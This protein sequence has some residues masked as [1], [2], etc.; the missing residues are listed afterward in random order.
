[1]QG[2]K[3]LKIV[4]RPRMN[5]D[6]GGLSC[7]DPV[8]SQILAC[9][10]ITKTEELDNSLKGL[11]QPCGLKDIEPAS[12]MLA[13]AIMQREH[14]MIAGDYDIDGMSGTALG[15]LVL[16]A[17]GLPEELI[18]YYVPSRYEDGYGLSTQVVNNALSQG[19]NLIVTVD[20]GIAAFDAVALA[21][22]QGLKVIVTDHHEVQHRLPEADAVVNPKRP[23]DNFQ[24]KNLSGVGVLF[25]LL[26]ATRSKLV[27]LGYFA[28][29]SQ[30]PS[31]GHFLDL[32]A[33]GTIGDMMPLDNNNRRLVKAGMKRIN[34][35]KAHCGINALLSLLKIDPAKARIRTI[36]FDLCPR[37][38]AA[39][40]IRISQNPAIL[41]LLSEDDNLALL[42]ARQLDMCN[43]RR[44]DHEKVMLKR[45]LEQYK[46]E[47]ELLAAINGDIDKA[48]V[49][50]VL[51][52]CGHDAVALLAPDDI[53]S[54]L[55]VLEKVND[56]E[57]IE[58]A[59]NAFDADMAKS[60]S[61]ISNAL[62]SGIVIYEPTFLSGLV[63][64]IATRMRERYHK[65]CIV[66][67]ADLGV[68]IDGGVDL[69][70]II[71][72]N[73]DNQPLPP[74]ESSGGRD[75]TGE[76]P[77][78]SSGTARA[79][80]TDEAASVRTDE[81]AGGTALSNVITLEGDVKV[82]LPTSARIFSVSSGI[83]PSIDQALKQKKHPQQAAEDED[84]S[85]EQKNSRLKG[86]SRQS[87]RK[88]QQA[89]SDNDIIPGEQKIVG[90]ARSCP[91]IDLMMVFEFIKQR[92][93]DIFLSCGG[94]AMAAGA[95][96]RA[97]DFAKFKAVF[98]EACAACAR[99]APEEEAIV[100][101]GALPDSHLCVEFA[102]DLE[103]LGPWG[104]GFEEPKF[105]GEFMI[106]QINLLKNRHLKVK[107]RTAGGLTVDGIKFRANLQEKSLQPGMLVQAVYTLNV[108]RYFSYP[109]LQLQLDGIEPL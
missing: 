8:L 17:F 80:A 82:E 65:P 14:I 93:P 30:A 51:A 85:D 96:I 69:M 66:F 36:A 86:K 73:L 67:G 24:S 77:D 101:D 83:V 97:R 3:A 29:L 104:K 56:I 46:Q 7:L 39:T 54:E 4:H 18:S 60:E 22:E 84:L 49:A 40:R 72:N 107:L 35:G 28:S 13:Q 92:E 9:R 12:Q 88:D 91:G 105:D 31:M 98:N 41:N 89:A 26:I 78:A 57:E 102:S 71:D 45:A 108:D 16:K 42:Y 33:L 99:E 55:Q 75:D 106:E 109:R 21:H 100:T 52:G 15:V 11:L 23:D 6:M 1:M 37:F 81:G 103:S 90:S 25:Y 19:V 32:V 38:N 76:A 50:H 48:N 43:R 74:A 70:S 27:D 94:H 10:G 68:G 64:L 62:E 44:M 58:D 79:G 20:N 87:G 61:G 47:R 53:G 95:S 5:R 63:G 59:F 34:S 2:V